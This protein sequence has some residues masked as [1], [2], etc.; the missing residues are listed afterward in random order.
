MATEKQ[1]INKLKTVVY[2]PINFTGGLE[3]LTL[4]LRNPSGSIFDTIVMSEESGGIYTA[5]YTPNALGN[6]QEKVSSVSNG[7]IVIHTYDVVSYDAD[8]IK[9][10]TDSIETKVDTVDGKVDTVDGKVD[11]IDGNIDSVKVTVETTD[12]KVDNI[13]TKVDGIYNN[14]NPGGYFA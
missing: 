6:W 12:G 14:V 3:D 4:T 9:T 8:D 2:V 10:Q 1:T 11:V 5:T 7:D 13:N